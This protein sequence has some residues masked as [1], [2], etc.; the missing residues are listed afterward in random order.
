MKVWL[1][2]VLRDSAEAAIPCLAHTLHYG[3]GVFEG[4][5]SYSGPQGCFIFRL[6]DHLERLVNSANTLGI[7]V[8]YS[9][10]EMEE[11]VQQ[12]LRVNELRDSYIRPLVFIGE[13]SMSLDVRKPPG[14]RVHTLIAAWEWKSYFGGSPQSGLNVKL[15][16]W[17]RNFPHPGLNRAKAV[18]FY[19]NSY[20][21]HAD[22]TSSGYDEAIL[23]DE[24]DHL[25]EATAANI[26]LVMDNRL[27]TPTIDAALAGITRDTIIEI[28]RDIG[29]AVEERGIPRA[30]I[31]RADQVFLT[32]TACEVVPV[33]KVNGRP[34]G[35]NAGVDIARRL[36][37]LYQRAVR[38]DYMQ[39]KKSATG[40]W[41]TPHTHPLIE[42]K[43]K[44]IG[45]T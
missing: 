34:I 42:A 35:N 13:G 32:G 3:T 5:R 10:D 30:D 29:L 6:R 14:N 40:Y 41:C 9:I 25:A 33:T 38:N 17:K 45:S 26:F 39:P 16:M 31:S 12:L 11:A 1:D 36:A 19:V 21:A 2:G 15:G 18:G 4:I 7:T 28:A 22:A 24:H 20:L 44:V 8:P 27:V 23:V 37:A 43:S